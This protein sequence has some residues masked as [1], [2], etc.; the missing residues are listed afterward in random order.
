MEFLLP[1]P[2][3]GSCILENAYRELTLKVSFEA[4]NTA[5]RRESST[6]KPNP[7][8]STRRKSW[9]RVLLVLLQGGD[10]PPVL[11]THE[12]PLEIQRPGLGPQL[13]KDVELLEGA[14][15]R[16]LR[17]IRGLEHLKRTAENVG[18]VKF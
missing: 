7:N 13:R 11:H 9:S 12:A 8:Q 5:P 10:C 3:Y 14:Q 1:F 15:R 16:A 18:F 2:D 6:Q 4:G 17:M